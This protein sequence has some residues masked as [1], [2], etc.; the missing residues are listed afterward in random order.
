MNRTITS[1]ALGLVMCLA[2]GAATVSTTLT[3]T[4]ASGAISAT[5]ITATG[6]A[7]LSGIG[8]GT[9]SGAVSLTPDSTGNISATFSITLTSGDKI[10][11][12]LSISASLLT[13]SGTAKGTITGGTGAY[14]GATGSFPT[15]QGTGALSGT[16]FTLSFTGAGSITTG[17]SGGGG[18]GP[19]APAITA[20]L[21]AGSYTANIAQGSIFVV[22]GTNLSAAGYTAMSFP[23]P[24]TSGNVKITFA[25]AAGGA[26]TDAYL[27]YLYNQ[28]GVNQLAAL[29]P[30]TVAV[31]NYNV[32]VTYNNV[33]SAAFT[34]QVVQRKIGLITADGSGSGLAVIQNFISQS[35]LDIDRLTTFSANGYTFSPSKPG[36]VLIAWAVGMGP[37][38]GGDNTASPGFDFS[39]NGVNVQV[40]VGG[41]TIKPLYAGR[42]PGLA[43]ADQINF[44]LPANIPTGCT[45]S[46][47]VSVN[48][49]LSNSTYIAIAQDAGSTACTLPGFTTQQLQNFDN[50]AT[51]TVG[52]FDLLQL[53]T[54][55]P[56]VGTVKIDSIS[57]AFTQY[58]G[59]SLAGAAAFQAQQTGAGACYVTHSTSNNNTPVPTFGGGKNLDAGTI[60]LSGPTG[61]NLSATPLKQDADNNYS[62]SIGTEGISIPGGSNG[63]IV[64]GTYS[65]AGGGGKEVGKFS[66]QITLG[67]PLTLSAPLPTTV[68]R[69]AGLTLNWT[70][71]NASDLVE[72]I[73][74]SSTTTG[75]GASAVTDT[76]TF[77][78]TTTAGKGTINVP[79]SIL[80]QLPA[81][82]VSSNGTGGGF[83]EF[84]SSVNPATFTAPLV[85]GGNTDFGFFL[86]LLG[87]GGQAS[88]Q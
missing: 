40:I 12:T 34:V 22:K 13:G 66:T 18:T 2:A 76:W 45:V 88:Y 65:L 50:G 49:Q 14:A 82:T 79:S 16:G 23:L 4:N 62:L 59:F 61:S 54:T 6:P 80:T 63:S 17:G 35:Q 58:N 72:V 1:C 47:Q 69:G 74:S 43:G 19:T 68:N 56:S 9:F 84:A 10:N 44:Q 53:A 75:T 51:F 46:F 85:A 20:V 55:V 38:S 31:G 3:V 41:V 32:T 28:G 5:G 27:V 77:I 87:T 52:S 78:C 57:G 11:G 73:G 26:S 21:D 81:S 36:Q 70:G 24:T 7:T 25:P 71:G 42:A 48:G 83:L 15:L 86:S 64:A 39:A 30:S 33:A 37:V 29:L 67:A 60:T 8:S